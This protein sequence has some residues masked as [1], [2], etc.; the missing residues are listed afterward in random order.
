MM[1]PVH[2]DRMRHLPPPLFGQKVVA[3]VAAESVPDGEPKHMCSSTH[4][5]YP[6]LLGVSM[7]YARSAEQGYGLSEPGG[8]FYWI[9]EAGR[10]QRSPK[11]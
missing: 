1:D 2:D 11:W 8:T 6:F 4:S 10:S 9:K 7:T 3:H 5:H